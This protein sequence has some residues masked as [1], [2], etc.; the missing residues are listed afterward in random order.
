MSFM[1]GQGVL[2]AYTASEDLIG[3]TQALL[4]LRGVIVG[5]GPCAQN[6]APESEQLLVVE[7]DHEIPGGHDCHGKAKALRGLYVT[8]KHLQLA[9]YVTVP[10]CSAAYTQFLRDR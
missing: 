6:D 10:D 8:A 9:E 1:V 3:V 7:I 2:V 4:P 5:H